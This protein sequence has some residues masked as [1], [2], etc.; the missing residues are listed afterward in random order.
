MQ[1][2][3]TSTTLILNLSTKEMRVLPKC[4]RG[5]KNSATYKKKKMRNVTWSFQQL[6]PSVKRGTFY[7]LSSSIFFHS[8]HI[9]HFFIFSRENETALQRNVFKKKKD[10]TRGEGVKKKDECESGVKEE[11]DEEEEEVAGA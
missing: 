6:K 10:K 7:R 3:Y 9:L 4:E 1:K 5:L 2:S 11:E 8:L